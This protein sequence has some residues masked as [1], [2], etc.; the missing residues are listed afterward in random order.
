MEVNVD[1]GEGGS[2]DHIFMPHVSSCSI[3]CGGHYG[4][5]STIKKTIKLASDHSVK[6]GSHPSYPDKINFGRK[7]ISINL[8]DLKKSI[9]FQLLSFK[10]ALNYFS[11]PWHHCKAHGALYNDMIKDENLT[12]AYF[13]VLK[14]FPEIEYI[15]L[16]AGQEIVNTAKSYK[17]KVLREVFSD[18]YYN[19][20]LTLISRTKKSSI[21]NSTS[22][23][24]EN[25]NFLLE[26]KINLSNK[27]KKEIFFDT[28]CLH[29]DHE[30]SID[31]IKVL[32]EKIKKQ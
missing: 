12:N 24:L 25:L 30:K 8:K 6:I 10:K 27:L 19:D 9:R 7:S 3:A 17:Y 32:S 13:Q 14:E 23:F 22:L 1:I 16:P 31:F 5:F 2:N 20:D 29:N 18:R 11:L 4:S 26:G 21:V 28:I 15:I